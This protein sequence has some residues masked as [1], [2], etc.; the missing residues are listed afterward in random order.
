MVSFSIWRLFL[1]LV[2][3]FV[4]GLFVGTNLGVVVICLMILRSR[5]EEGTVEKRVSVPKTKE[6]IHAEIDGLLA[7]KDKVR[8]YSIFGDDN[9][10][11]IK[12]QIRVLSEGMGEDDIY[13]EFGSDEHTLDSAREALDWMQGGWDGGL[14][15]DWQQLVQE[16]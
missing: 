16:E 14:A 12:A 2:L 4:G 6:E 15:E 10:A 11:A 7:L 5:D 3:A 8:R 9:R 1:V 13:E